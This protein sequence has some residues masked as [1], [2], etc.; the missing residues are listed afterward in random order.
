MQ[1]RNAGGCGER[2]SKRYWSEKIEEVFAKLHE[3][4]NKINKKLG[5]IWTK[6]E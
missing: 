6:V 5:K 1:V 3:E 2:V 4:F